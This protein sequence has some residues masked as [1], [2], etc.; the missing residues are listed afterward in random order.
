MC[1]FVSILAVLSSE[2]H[3]CFALFV[4]MGSIDCCVALPHDTTDLFAV[5]DYG[6]SLPYSL[7]LGKVHQIWVAK[8]NLFFALG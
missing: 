1:C 2:L 4:F 5:C 6:I 7:F 3:G 8:I